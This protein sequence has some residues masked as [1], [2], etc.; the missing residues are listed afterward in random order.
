MRNCPDVNLS[1]FTLVQVSE[2]FPTFAG[3][4]FQRVPY[5]KL[6]AVS[7]MQSAAEKLSL[8]YWEEILRFGPA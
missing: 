5:V 8:L 2:N 7:E 6:R 4:Y 3:S 1:L